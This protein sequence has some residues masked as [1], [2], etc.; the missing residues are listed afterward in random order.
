M[1]TFTNFTITVSFTDFN[2]KNWKT[3]IRDNTNPESTS[4][5][6]VEMLMLRNVHQMLNGA[7]NYYNGTL[8]TAYNKITTLETK[9]TYLQRKLSRLPGRNVTSKT[10]VPEPPTFAGSENKMQL[11]N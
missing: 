4:W 2:A 5:N 11:H 8:S 1:L 9:V 6:E 3:L 7:I 10:K